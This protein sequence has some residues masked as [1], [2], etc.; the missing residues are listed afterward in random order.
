MG[1]VTRGWLG[2]PLMITVQCVMETRP[3]SGLATL[4]WPRNW[5]WEPSGGRCRV[6]GLDTDSGHQDTRGLTSDNVTSDNVTSSHVLTIWIVSRD[7]VYLLWCSDIIIFTWTR[8]GW[9]NVSVRCPGLSWW[10][11]GYFIFHCY[12]QCDS[13]LGISASDIPWELASVIC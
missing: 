8:G 7:S 6:P 5:R 4:Q 1:L 12:P 9:H 10:T 11:D 3:S 2:W 13:R